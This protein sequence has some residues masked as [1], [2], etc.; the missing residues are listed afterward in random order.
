MQSF[1]ELYLCY[2]REVNAYLLSLCK[3]ASLAEELTQ[4]TFFKALKKYPTFEGRSRIRTW[5]CEI[6]KNLYFT[7]LRKQKRFGTPPCE[8]SSEE[9]FEQLFCDQD[10]ALRLHKVLHALAE[11]YRE[12]FSLRVFSELS[13]ADIAQLFGKSEGWARVTYHRAKGKLIDAMKGESL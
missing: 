12:V 2:F 6:A 13:F 4:E 8:I 11:P 5:L 7:H 9:D 3:D 1:E 10:D